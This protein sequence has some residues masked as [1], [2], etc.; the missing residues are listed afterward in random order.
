[1]NKIFLEFDRIIR[2]S[3]S[4]LTVRSVRISG[5]IANSIAERIIQRLVELTFIPYLVYCY[6]RNK[7]G[8]TPYPPLDETLSLGGIL[9]NTSS[10]K[11]GI[12]PYLY[13]YS[14]ALFLHDWI[15]T[16]FVIILS[17][18]PSKRVYK[19]A[20]LVF[21]I[22]QNAFKICG[23]KNSFEEFCRL[24]PVKP[25]VNATSLLIQNANDKMEGA[26]RI[27]FCKNP[28][29]ELIR[30]VELSQIQKIKLFLFHLSYPLVHITNLIRFPVSVLYLRDIAY[31]PAISM[32]DK[33]G[34]IEAVIITN[35]NY[36]AQP[37]WMR[38]QSKFNFLVHEVHYSQN[39]FPFTYKEESI[40]VDLPAFRHVRVDEHW[41]WTTQYGEHLTKLGHTGKIHVV[42]PILWF[43]PHFYSPAKNENNIR[44][45][46]FDVDPITDEVS[47]KFGLITNYYKTENMISFIEAILEVCKE[48]EGSIQKKISIQLK[49]K[50]QTVKNFHDETYTYF[51]DSMEM[52]YPNFQT[53]DHSSDTFLLLT[54]ADIS[55]SIPYT[56]VS[57]VAAWL[58]KPTIYFDPSN[59][60]LF[61]NESNPYIRTAGGREE[62]KRVMEKILSPSLTN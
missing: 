3:E 30:Y 47:A 15:K 50:R 51:I 32:L 53:V 62:L 16:L 13:F 4:W 10:G 20:T 42:G 8:E 48:L 59:K 49:H 1:M 31:L 40:S 26:D 29:F 12:T 58:M 57:Y 60:L 54:N 28:V 36:S 55:I 22:G 27:T 33:I 24:G 39:T 61:T 21:G 43:I 34:L 35:S 52:K 19:K 5:K 41:V 25:F 9:V 56:S 46:V 37:L 18:F 2:H 17:F 6:N 14:I 45:V 11:I 38:N 23:R 7:N 44:I